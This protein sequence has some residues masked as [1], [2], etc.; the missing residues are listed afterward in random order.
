VTEDIMIDLASYYQQSLTQKIEE[1]KCAIL[2][3]RISDLNTI[4][5][6]KIPIAILNHIIWLSWYAFRL[7]VYYANSDT[8]KSEKLRWWFLRNNH[9]FIF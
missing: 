6:K 9:K 1:I 7:D 2:E 8:H 5:K 3:K 4:M